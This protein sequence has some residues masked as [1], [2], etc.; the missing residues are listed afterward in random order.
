[1]SLSDPMALPLAS[2][3]PQATPQQ[4]RA[5]AN[6]AQNFEGQL[7][8]MMIQPMFEGLQTDGPFGGGQTEGAFR[9]FLTDAI[10]KQVAKAGG[11]GLAAPVAK[12]MLKMQGL[13]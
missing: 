5:I 10:G 1:M 2:T 8:A 13:S 11:I 12:E 7:M 3:L 4:R 9:S 6:T